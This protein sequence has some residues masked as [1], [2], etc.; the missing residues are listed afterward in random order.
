[1]TIEVSP[2][3]VD[4]TLH[5]HQLR[6]WAVG[7]GWYAEGAVSSPTVVLVGEDG[8][9][10][11]IVWYDGM[12]GVSRIATPLVSE[13]TVPSGTYTLRLE[14]T[15]HEVGDPAPRWPDRLG[16]ARQFQVVLDGAIRVP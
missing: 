11:P 5:S 9:E 14:G 2:H 1:M 10:H 12:V 6:G 8:Q 15:A 16:E 3:R 7:D 13:R 4:A